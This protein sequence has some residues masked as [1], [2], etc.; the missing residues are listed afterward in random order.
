MLQDK[1]ILC[2][3]VAAVLAAIN[4]FSLRVTAAQMRGPAPELARMRYVPARLVLKDFTRAYKSP[5]DAKTIKI[6]YAGKARTYRDTVG[7]ARVRG[8]SH[9]VAVI[10]RLTQCGIQ[11]RDIWEVRYY[12]LEGD[13]IFKEIT[14]LKSLQLTRLPKKPPGLADADLTRLVS[15][16][17]MK[18]YEGYQ[19][20]N[21]E[22]IYKKG[23]WTLCTPMYNTR[24]KIT[25]AFTD[26]V[27]NEVSTY[28]CVIA[29][30]LALREGKWED[31]RLGCV[32]DGRETEECV[33]ATSCI[34]TTHKSSIPEIS[35]EDGA[36]LLRAAFENE[37]G[38]VRTNLFVE[39]F[40][41]IKRLPVENL[42][43]TFPCIVRAVF[44]V[45][46][47]KSVMTSE[48]GE[49]AKTLRKT[50]VVYECFVYGRLSYSPTE[51]KWKAIIDH[52]C[53]S[54]SRPCM[55]PCSDPGK[56]CKR[57]GEK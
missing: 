11:M 35:D 6:Y 7:E 13:W 5:Q 30:T 34:E 8:Q 47:E 15:D 37:Y 18:R 52:C 3:N 28:E 25:T 55:W 22:V 23:Y 4:L 27:S 43:K 36:S 26:D 51:K 49:E 10:Y 44:D 54:E 56:G 24:S 17:F 46:E 41:L 40:D 57:L 53:E 45:D 39:R 14:R 38:L 48:S 50:R 19:V 33:F 20:Q 9:Q 2:A 42:N 16:A 1:S 21:I 12:D 32:V 29:A 31:V